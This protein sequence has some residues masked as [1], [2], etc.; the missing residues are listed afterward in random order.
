MN[1]QALMTGGWLSRA[2]RGTIV[3]GLAGLLACGVG[4]IACAADAAAPAPGKVSAAAEDAALAQQVRK[5]TALAL[6]K[7]AR[8]LK[9]ELRYLEAEKKLEQALRYD[10]TLQD[11]QIE[12]DFVRFQLGR[13]PGERAETTRKIVEDQKLIVEQAQAQLQRLFAEGE[14]LLA[15]K[16]YEQAL[17]KFTRVIEIDGYNAWNLNMPDLVA[18]A[19]TQIQIC[20]RLLEDQKVEERRARE[21]ELRARSED[22]YK[23]DLKYMENLIKKYKSEAREGLAA[24][25]FDKAELNAGQVLEHDP[26]DSEAQEIRDKA[27][28]LRHLF[29]RVKIE[30]ELRRNW[31]LVLRGILDTTVPYH[32]IFR[33]PP[34][35][36]W[37]KLGKERV[38]LEEQVASDEPV[39][40]RDVRRILETTKIQRISFEDRPLK[41]VLDYLSQ[42]AGVSFV[43]NSKAREAMEGDELK[44]N[45]AE[46]QGL[47]LN[48]VLNIVLEGV[49]EGYG[50]Q[51]QNGAVVIGPRSSLSEK[52]Y[53]D[54]YAVDDIA[55]QH[56]D[57]PAPPMSVS[58]STQSDQGGNVV[59]DTPDAAADKGPPIGPQEL[60]ELIVKRIFAGKEENGTAQYQTGKLVVRTTLENHRKINELLESLRK[61]SGVLVSC[62][63]RFIDV[64]DNMLEEIGV[65]IGGPVESALEYP[66]P[67]VNGLGTSVASGYTFLDQSMRYETRAANISDYSGVLGTEV[68]PFNITNRGGMALQWNILEDYQL[69]AILTMVQKKQKARSLDA[70]RVIAFDSQTAHTMVIDQIAYIK[71]VDVN[72][73]GVSP[74][75]NPLIGSFR[76][77]S[78]L[79]IRPT[80]TH[81]RKF[82]ILE[83]KPTTASHVDSKYAD[84]S[85]AQGFTMVSVELPVILLAQIKT[86][87]TVPDGGSV[88]V[89]GLKKVIEQEKSIGIP[90][91]QRIPILNV[92][93]GRR[94]QS[95]LHSSLFVMIKSNVVIVREEEQLNFP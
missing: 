44:V 82:V 75:I 17:G 8:A 9:E 13:L 40:N 7:E 66:I 63:A 14:A 32:H 18:A 1:A 94:G 23:R 72:Q 31:D 88:L 80:V 55:S 11:A 26:R 65:S 24:S 43:P 3:L 53:L 70:P 19:R 39:A 36:V 52:M 35:K 16:Q 90:I 30:R 56:P 89:G 73:T 76:V 54:F 47:L 74:V 84:L 57:F 6:L 21:Q 86:T 50:Y 41:E 60:V 81:D 20:T 87:I 71:D 42:I 12:L 64:Q 10:A 51:V 58:L 33:F 91:I 49:G 37:E 83:V 59:L 77:G 25:N 15:Q 79:E 28:Y 67:D 92:L 5:E 45:L 27:R 38:S 46:V 61:L 34:R 95:Q 22:E 62:E 78:L 85:L 93:F 29:S 4:S 2:A 69:E 68:T 48:N